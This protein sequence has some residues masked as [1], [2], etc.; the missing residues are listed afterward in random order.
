MHPLAIAAAE[1]LYPTGA[2][3]AAVVMARLRLMPWFCFPCD[4]SSQ[5]AVSSTI[6][7][8]CGNKTFTIYSVHIV[9]TI[10]GFRF[11]AAPTPTT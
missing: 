4:K 8:F 10:I 7:A 5:G 11:E 3:V 6:L 1:P 9:C 2:A